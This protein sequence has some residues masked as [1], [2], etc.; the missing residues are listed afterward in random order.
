MWNKCGNWRFV[1]LGHIY[2]T[3]VG[4]TTVWPQSHILVCL[5]SSVQLSATLWTIVARL[6]QALLSMGFPRQA[7][8]SRVPFPSPGYLLHPGTEPA[9]LALQVGS[10]PSEPPGKPHVGSGITW[11][12]LFKFSYLWTALFTQLITFWGTGHEDFNFWTFLRE[13]NPP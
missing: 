11:I 9:S 13:H 10:L 3:G 6:C 5:F 12:I 1:I 4:A 2:K 7:Y 8:C